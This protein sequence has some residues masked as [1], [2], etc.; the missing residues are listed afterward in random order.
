MTADVTDRNSH[1]NKLLKHW[2]QFRFLYIFDNDKDPI[3]TSHPKLL[4]Q[5]FMQLVNL[6]LKQMNCAYSSRDKLGPVCL[7]TQRPW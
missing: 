2:Y 4:A 3:L 1:N 6:F 7:K 5:N